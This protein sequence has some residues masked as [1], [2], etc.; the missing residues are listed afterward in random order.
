MRA[1]CRPRAAA[2]D[3]R[4]GICIEFYGIARQW[5]GVPQICLEI[6]SPE[7]TFANVL[8]L[9][10]DRLAAS[11][12]GRIASGGRLHS[13]LSANL[14]GARFISDPTTPIHAGQCLLILSADAGG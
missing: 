3:A 8:G 6:P 1:I 7:T 11:G 12:D 2:Y 9:M 14:D 10:N 13:T 5:A 4:M